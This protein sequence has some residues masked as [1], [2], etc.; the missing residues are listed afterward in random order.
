[1][2]ITIRKLTAKEAI[3]SAFTK[4]FGLV[5]KREVKEE[6][7]PLLPAL[8]RRDVR[9]RMLMNSRPNRAIPFTIAYLLNIIDR[10]E[11]DQQRGD[12]SPWLANIF[13]IINSWV[14]KATKDQIESL[15]DVE[16]FPFEHKLDLVIE[17][18]RSRGLWLADG[19][20][21][22]PES[23]EEAELAAGTRTSASHNLKSESE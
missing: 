8:M 9:V 23:G 15:S 22:I 12:I 7:W 13:N 3:D 20:T 19:D 17:V 5:N 14:G 11:S 10:I 6:E 2:S 21:A 16:N 18:L 1:M 4:G